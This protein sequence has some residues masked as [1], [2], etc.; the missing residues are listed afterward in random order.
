M[1]K[2]AKLWDQMAE[3]YSEAPIKNPIAY[4]KKMEVSRYFF[5]PDM[6][7]LEFG[8]GT[9]SSAILHAPFVDHIRAIDISENMLQIAKEKTKEAGIGNILF[10]LKAIEDLEVEGDEFDAV[11]ALNVLHLLEDPRLAIR[12][13]H[14]SLKPGG[15]FISSTPCFGDVRAF[16]KH[17]LPIG[18]FLGLLPTVKIFTKDGLTKLIQ[19]VEFKIEYGYRP[20]INEAV[21]FV[22]RKLTR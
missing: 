16:W 15:I 1:Y 21:F 10:E 18:R 4:E 20:N 14:E 5:N 2:Q 17:L 13:A 8:C 7:I 6:K 11:L 3:K 12:K 19:S 9:G 22:F